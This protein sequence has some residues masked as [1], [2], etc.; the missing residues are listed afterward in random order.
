MVVS[1]F[2]LFPTFFVITSASFLSSPPLPFPFFLF[3]SSP[4]S[5]C[6]P[7]L[8]VAI[9]CVFNCYRALPSSTPFFPDNP[10]AATPKPDDHHDHCYSPDTGPQAVGNR[11]NTLLCFPSQ[12]TLKVASEISKVSWQQAIL[13]FQRQQAFKSFKQLYGNRFN[14][15]ASATRAVAR[16]F[17]V[18]AAIGAAEST[19]RSETWRKDA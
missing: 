14:G 3:L 12:V 17:L 10:T 19:I 16:Q 8:V 5:L 13:L 1:P 2:S 15:P 11:D 18:S 6:L 9:A 7:L 4:S